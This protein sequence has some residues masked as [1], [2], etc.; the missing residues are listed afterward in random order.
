MLNQKGLSDGMNNLP[1]EDVIF[2]QSRPMKAA[3]QIIRKAANADVPLLI[4]GENGTG[5]EVL[6]RFVHACSSWSKGPFVKV[7]CAAIPGTLIESELFG[8][9]KGAFTGANTCKRG[10]VEMARGGTLFL[11]EIVELVPSVQAKLL[12]FLQ[13]SQFS[14][15]GG[16]EEKHVETRIICATNR[17]LEEEIEGGRFRSDLFYR[18]NVIRIK[19]PPLVDRREDIPSLANYFLSLSA[20][21]FQHS[22]PLLS[23]EVMQALQRRNWPGNIREL[24]NCM[25]RCVILGVRDGLQIGLRDSES[26]GIWDDQ[27]D[28]GLIP[29]KQIAQRARRELER[30]V[31]LKALQAHNWNGRKTAEALR[32]SYR[33]LL[34]KVRE[35]GLISLRYQSRLQVPN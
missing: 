15:I 17:R 14:R 22:V 21:R 12:H 11:D 25:A 18:I 29:L 32:I 34:Y 2:G 3:R 35:A 24:E 28:E 7:N 6:A 31:I 10:R 13:D 19:L 16:N 30:K 27:E 20:E 5:K 9:E 4:E 26:S 33:A 8:Y 23:R 1:P